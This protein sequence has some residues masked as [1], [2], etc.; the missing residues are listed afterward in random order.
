M[1]GGGESTTKSSARGEERDLTFSPS[2]CAPGESRVRCVCFPAGTPVG[3]NVGVLIW[4]LFP[5]SPV[6]SAFSHPSL[7][8]FCGL[9]PSGSSVANFTGSTSPKYTLCLFFFFLL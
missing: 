9:R 1:R 2:V 6:L 3:L 7:D 8:F 5:F 4:L